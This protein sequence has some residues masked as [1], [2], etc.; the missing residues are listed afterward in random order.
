V[1]AIESKPTT[2]VVWRVLAPA[3]GGVGIARVLLLGIIVAGLVSTSATI[4]FEFASLIPFIVS[5]ELQRRLA[6][7]FCHPAVV[8]GIPF[9]VVV[10]LATFH[11]PASWH[12]ALNALGGWRRLML[13]PLCV[14]VFD[15]AASK[16]LVCKVL[17][18]FCLLAALVSFVTQ[19]ESI[20]ILHKLPPGVSFHNYTVQGMTFSIAIIVCI[21]AIMR[22]E[23]F[24]GDRVLGDRRIMAAV[25]AVLTFDI[26]FVLWGRSGYLALL[27]MTVAVVTLLVRGSWRA[28]ALAGFGV[29]ACV[30]LLLA[31]DAQ[32]RSRV[33]Q[34]LREFETADQST[35]PTSLGYRAVFWPTTLRMVRDH[36]IFGVG[37]GGFADGY[38]PYGQGVEGWRGN[39]TGDP[40]NQFLK[41]LG[42][43]GLIGLVAFLFLIFRAL[44]CPAPAPYR[45]LA[46][47]AL[48]CWCATSMANSHFSTFV[49][50]RLIFFWLG[51]M[52]AY[53]PA[54]GIDAASRA[55]QA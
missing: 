3:D 9:A 16:R 26:V 31:S 28:K 8:G 4:V 29:L 53:R 49:E 30:G 2:S 40:H 34:A 1:R 55:S 22:P 25:I 36:P 10:V 21:A 33:G 32:V 45:Q 37:T 20:S 14:A 23:A 35:K 6:Q 27:V 12:D 48:I 15:D 42:E 39:D 17:V 54:D 5:R 50:G 13:G 46:S 43:Q 47:A 51:A 18:L 52:L 7:A 24:A 41:I 19:W 44:A 38:R 11:G